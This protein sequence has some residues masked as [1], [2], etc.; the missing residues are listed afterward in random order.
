MIVLAHSTPS[1]L[2][3]AW[4]TWC[5]MHPDSF[6]KYKI[7]Q[8]VTANI[9]ALDYSTN[10][11]SA[12]NET[13]SRKHYSQKFFY[14]ALRSAVVV[15]SVKYPVLFALAFAG[16]QH[17]NSAF[18]VRQL[19]PIPVLLWQMLVCVLCEDALFYWTHRFLHIKVLY[20]LF[21]KKHHEFHAPVTF[22]AEHAHIVE[23][24]LGNAVPFFCGPLL[25]Q[26]N[27]V[28][29]ALWMTLRMYKTC[30]AHCGYNFPWMPFS[31]NDTI[32]VGTR[33]HDFHHSANTGNFGSF[34]NFWDSLCGTDAY[35]QKKCD[36]GE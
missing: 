12:V 7:Q 24:A 14:D 3:F 10:A 5:D 36:R 33:R 8:A 4:C 35:A 31:C 28:S 20:P 21:H 11:R 2:M 9:L 6:K 19:E 34:F 23:T 26:C 32:F 15:H 13:L 27:I 1:V 16:S 25:L 18:L 29:L 17:Y 22:A 30:E